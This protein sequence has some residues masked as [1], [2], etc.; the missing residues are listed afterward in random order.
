MNVDDRSGQD[1]NDNPAENR[2]DPR[3]AKEVLAGMYPHPLI[4]VLPKRSLQQNKGQWGEKP[5]ADSRQ[6]SVKAKVFTFRDLT[7]KVAVCPAAHIQ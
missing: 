5:L 2:N 1:G 3:S 7:P 4:Q 6:H